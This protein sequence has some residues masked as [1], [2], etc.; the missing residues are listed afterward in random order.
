MASQTPQNR[1]C[2]KI[3]PSSTES[4]LAGLPNELLLNILQHAD[5]PSV[6]RLRETSKRFVPVCNDAVKS[7]AKELKVIYVHPSPSSVKRA[8]T[9]CHL[10]LSSEVEEVC[11]VSKNFHS[12]PDE[13][14]HIYPA[15]GPSAFPWLAREPLSNNISQTYPW[16]RARARN[17]IH[18]GVVSKFKSSYRE[19][20]SSLAGLKITRFSFSEVCDQPGFNIIS[21]Q[22]IAS[23]RE[24][25]EER[26]AED[27]IIPPTTFKFADSDALASVLHD[28]RFKFTSLRIAHELADVGLASSLGMAHIG[29]YR[30]LTH[31]D[32]TVNH[33]DARQSAWTWLYGDFLSSAASSLVELKIGFQYRDLTPKHYTRNSLEA[34]LLCIFF[35]V[36]LPQ[37]RRLEIHRF[38]APDS[39]LPA[40]NPNAVMLQHFGLG[41]FV[42]GRCRKLQFLKL[43][44][45]FPAHNGGQSPPQPWKMAD[46]VPVD[47]ET[48]AREIEGLDAGTRA[49]EIDFSA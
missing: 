16:T 23:W 19:L 8:I 17:Q 45:V 11:F 15:A 2:A 14:G 6:L 4:S 1:Q 30:A 35:R 29:G 36:H 38:P 39:G 21:N 26:T 7:K 42:A 49:W 44:N 9:I 28:P 22:R 47:L 24:A 32:L 13:N 3:I 34:D 25:V 10:D 43:T 12:R 40:D 33:G 41:R 46:F 48:V 37:L 18:E 31:L 27:L 5:I 20:L